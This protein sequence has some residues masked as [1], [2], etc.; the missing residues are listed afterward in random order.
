MTTDYLD[1]GFASVHAAANHIP[2]TFEVKRNPVDSY[3]NAGTEVHAAGC[4]DVIIDVLPYQVGDLLCVE[5]DRG[6]LTCDGGG[7]DIV[8]N[9]EII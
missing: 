3:R 7:E 8:M 1:L 4:M 6:T 5:L 9:T 2:I